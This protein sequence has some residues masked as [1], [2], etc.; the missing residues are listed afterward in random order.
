MALGL[1]FQPGTNQVGFGDRQSGGTGGGTG[2][3]PLQTALQLLSLRLPTRV[4][5]SAIA[6]QALLQ[7]QGAAGAPGGDPVANLINKLLAASRTAVPPTAVPPTPAPQASQPAAGPGPS[8][9]PVG[10]DQRSG[11]AP[12][13]SPNPFGGSMPSM[14]PLYAPQAPNYAPTRTATPRIIPSGG[15]LRTVK[16]TPITVNL[17]TGAAVPNEP[18]PEIRFGPPQA[19]GIDLSRIPD[20]LPQNIATDFLNR[21]RNPDGSY[22]YQRLTPATFPDVYGK[23]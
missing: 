2:A 18:G 17:A 12:P 8:S 4:S 23:R 21:N 11:A 19:N 15:D 9:V 14:P 22:D 7:S 16:P 3:P 10:T 1:S 6:P 13:L 5:P 20:W